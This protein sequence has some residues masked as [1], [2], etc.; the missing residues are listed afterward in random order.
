MELILIKHEHTLKNDYNE[1]LASKWSSEHAM[2]LRA[3]QKSISCPTHNQ[4]KILKYL[5]QG[6]KIQQG[7]KCKNTRSNKGTSVK[8]KDNAI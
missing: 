5:H 1:H 8:Y 7:H 3:T 4:C 2:Q 6:Y